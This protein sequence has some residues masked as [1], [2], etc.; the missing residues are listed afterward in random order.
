MIYAD[1][2]SDRNIVVLTPKDEVTGADLQ[3]ISAKIDDYIN[4]HDKVPSLVIRADDLPHWKNFS[5]LRQHLKLIHEHHKIVPKVAFVTDSPALSFASA[6]ARQFVK[7]RVRRFSA[8]HMDEAMDWAARPDDDPGRFEL[9]KGLP[10]DVLALHV[11]G[12]ITAEDYRKMLVP[13]VEAMLKEHDRIKVLVVFDHAFDGYS[14][15]AIWEDLKLGLGHLRAFSKLAVVTDLV[16]LR[17]AVMIFS[18]IV[19]AR[20]KTF[21]LSQLDAAKE[22]IKW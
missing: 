1:F 8:A 13:T 14:A 18:P 17:R 10:H 11:S 7:A 6:L 22:W 12:I 21:P 9:I 16:W 3:A 5:A 4:H 20:V 2:D 15:N 19:P